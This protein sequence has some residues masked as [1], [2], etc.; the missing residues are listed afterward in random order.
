MSIM[1]EPEPFYE[2][3]MRGSKNTTKLNVFKIIVIAQK[4]GLCIEKKP[5]PTN[6]IRSQKELPNTK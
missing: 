3:L 2:K 1:P 5:V 4:T 6:G